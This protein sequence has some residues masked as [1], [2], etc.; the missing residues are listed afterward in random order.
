MRIA[1]C[2]AALATSSLVGQLPIQWYA[3]TDI[4]PERRTD[5]AMVQ[6]TVRDR[7]VSFGGVEPDFSNPYRAYFADTWEW[8]GGGW[9]GRPAASP[10]ARSGHAMAY[11]ALR[12][13][14]ILCGGYRLFHPKFS[15]TY[16]GDTW[17]WDGVAWQQMTATLPPRT[18]HV[19]TWHAGLGQVVVF[20]G[21]NA[22]STL[23][24]TLRLNGGQW[25]SLGGIGPPA[26]AGLAGAY[27]DARARWVVFGDA[28]VDAWEFDGASWQRRIANPRPSPRSGSAMAYD[29][30]RQRIVL[31][32]GSIALYVAATDLWEWDG[33]AWHLVT[34]S[35]PPRTGHQAAWQRASSRML[36][37]GGYNTAFGPLPGGDRTVRSWDGAVWALESESDAGSWLASFGN[38]LVSVGI[39]GTYQWVEHRWRRIGPPPPSATF[40]QPDAVSVVED[41]V[42]QRL[43]LIDSTGGQVQEFDGTSWFGPFACPFAQRI[44]TAVAFDPLRGVVVVFGGLSFAPLPSA[45]NDTWEW[46]GSSWNARSL[47]TAPSPRWGAAIGFDPGLGALLL[48]G[49]SALG[50]FP[51]ADTWVLQASSWQQVPTATNP[52][53]SGRL[54]LHE[55]EGHLYLGGAGLWQWTGT[56]WLQVSSTST[57]VQA[58]AYDRRTARLA[59]LRADGQML[60]FGPHATPGIAFSGTGCGI[61][62]RTA[63]LIATT[64]FL[65]NS[66]LVIDVLDA[67]PQGIGVLALATNQAS[68][69]ILAGCDLLVGGTVCTN[70]FFV[71]AAGF[72]TLTQDIPY[73][74]SLRGA[75]FHAQALMCDVPSLTLAV[76]GRLSLT[77]GD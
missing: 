21:R 76:T 60:H 53:A 15:P 16:Y 7:I 75:T 13:R 8:I 58:E 6:D 50:G 66:R 5:F 73:G 70:L 31:Q 43:V 65:G 12:Q 34:T 23:G 27:D 64:P 25:Q 14:V 17:E 39:R 46:N 44:R 38:S 29:P 51:L 40:I 22:L 52:L 1:G 32:G 59:S 72:A 9:M 62:P 35:L 47:S 45:H 74:E 3:P 48:H 10:S 54:A 18:G 41:T 37:Y 36:F 11:D 30:L 68:I 42:R 77:L 20:G 26:S 19:M 55:G 24:D 61:G 28:A 57:Y 71:D 56:D 33:T 67:P 63:R 4:T 69:P 49:G 2:V